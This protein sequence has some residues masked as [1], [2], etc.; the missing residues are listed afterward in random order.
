MTVSEHILDFLSND[1]LLYNV[2][3]LG[4]DDT[5]LKVWLTSRKHS[6]G[7]CSFH[8]NPYKEHVMASGRLDLVYYVLCLLYVN[9][10]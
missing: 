6:M 1:Y 7:V 9:L 8:S 2:C 10:Y 3:H 4:G 5:K